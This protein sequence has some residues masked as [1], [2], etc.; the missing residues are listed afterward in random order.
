VRGRRLPLALIAVALIGGLVALEL[1]TSGGGGGSDRKTAPQLPKAVLVAPGA[2]LESLAGKP[3]VVNFWASW[4]GPCREEAA[5]LQSF[6]E[7]AH[8]RATL[9]GVNWTDELKGARS[10]IRQYHWTFANLRD[11]GGEIGNEWFRTTGNVAGLPVTYVLDAGGRIASVL[12]GPQTEAKLD[13]AVRDAA[14]S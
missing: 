2:T 11:S 10:F 8:G 13:R 9:V 1:A 12:R 14:Q 7:H 3:A 4:C 5:H 6:S